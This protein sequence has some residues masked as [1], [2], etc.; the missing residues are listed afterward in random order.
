MTTSTI[1][2]IACAVLVLAPLAAADEAMKSKPVGAVFVNPS[3]IKWGEAPPELPKGAQLAVLL[4]DPTKA[5]P[6]VIRLKAPDGYKIPPHWHTQDE[7]LTILSGTFVLHMGD[8]MKAEPHTLAV[9]AYHFLP[10]TMHHAAEVSGETIVQVT[11]V[12]PF[13]IH[14]LNAADRPNPKSASR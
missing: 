12:G 14:Y 1:I 7:H 6:F 13:D 10:N 5:G 8:T 11:G 3:D 9:G 4:G 2:R